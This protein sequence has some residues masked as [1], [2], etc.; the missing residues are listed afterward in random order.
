MKYMLLLYG[1]E[2]DFD[3]LKPAE[4]RR[5]I[6]AFQAYV[7]A[8][9]AEGVLVSNGRLADSKRAVQVT[10]KSGKLQV[11]DGPYVDTIEQLGGYFIIDVPDR[12]T[13]LIWAKRCRAAAT[14]VIEVKPFYSSD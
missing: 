13:A 14:D 10:G 1:R 2:D 5:M 11:L 6:A 9:R 8:M 3:T 7:D 4:Q 12:D